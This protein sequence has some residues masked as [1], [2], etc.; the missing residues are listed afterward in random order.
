MQS[1]YTRFEK[2]VGGL[3]VSNS[4]GIEIGALTTPLLRPPDADIRFVDHVDSKALR[5]K[6]RNDPAVD[7]GSIVPVDAVWGDATLAACFPGETFDYVIASQ[8]IEHVPDMIGWL[9]E[10]AAVLRPNGRLILAIP[11]KR[12][13]FDI[14]RRETSLSDLIDSNL[15]AVRRPTPGQVFDFNANAVELD[16]VTAWTAMPAIGSLRHYL[17]KPQALAKARESCSGSYVDSHCSVFTARSLLELLAGLLELQLL[18][19]RLERFHVAP[20]GSNEMSLILLRQ[21]AEADAGAACNAIALMLQDGVDSEGLLLD[22]PDAPDR[23]AALEQALVSMRA[24]TCWRMTAPLRTLK[25]RLAPLAHRLR[26]KP[27][28][29]KRETR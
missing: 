14:L 2:L 3:D 18:P 9:A 7:I 1:R 17:T 13:T 28:R 6:Y 8:V 22:T 27:A 20:S 4:R 5:D 23:V 19:F 15:H 25:E 10:V 26:S 24:S 16:H 11:D 29:S 12:Y 21:P